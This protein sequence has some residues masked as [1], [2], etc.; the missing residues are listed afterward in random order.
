MNKDLCASWR[1]KFSSVRGFTLIELLV[2]ITIIGIL[3]SIVLVSLNSARSKARDARRKADMRQL[4][5]ALEF[6]YDNNGSYPASDNW[7][8][9]EP[10]D[11]FS[12]NGGNWI[13]GLVPQYMPTLPRDPRGVPSSIPVCGSSYK[14][15]Y[16]YIAP[17]GATSYKLLAHCSPE[18]AWTSS[19]S[20]FDPVRPIHAWMLCSGPPA[21]GL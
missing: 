19:D 3:S 11:F 10:G 8:S 14:S 18:N 13:P 15:A 2:V 6:Y 12:N 17:F 1:L 7:L 20:F 9:S 5:I 16:L 21:C 4:Q